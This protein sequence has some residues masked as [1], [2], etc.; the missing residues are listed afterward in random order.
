[1]AWRTGAL[2][3]QPDNRSMRSP[4]VISG[5]VTDSL[6]GFEENGGGGAGPAYGIRQRSQGGRYVSVAALSEAA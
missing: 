5:D 4:T 3:S 6:L 1:M 2:R